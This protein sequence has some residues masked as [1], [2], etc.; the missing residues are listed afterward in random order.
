LPTETRVAKVRHGHEIAL[1]NKLG[2]S[3]RKQ[4][5][6]SIV[7]G[8]RLETIRPQIAGYVVVEVDINDPVDWHRVADTD[9]F[10]YFLHGKVTPKE[11]TELAQNVDEDNVVVEKEEEKSTRYAPGDTLIITNGSHTG[12]QIT[13]LQHKGEKIKAEGYL[14]GGPTI[15]YIRSSCC[16]LAT[17]QDAQSSLDPA[18]ASALNRASLPPRNRRNRKR[19]GRFS[20]VRS[21]A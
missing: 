18:V 6:I 11:K 2:A 8:K 15:L 4:R 21:N 5:H 14:L 3:I 19:H 10:V 7:R 20:K 1:A 17:E 16:V 13:C 9:G 12:L